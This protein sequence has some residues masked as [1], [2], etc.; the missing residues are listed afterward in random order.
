[1]PRLEENRGSEGLSPD[2]WA[3]VLEFLHMDEV[4]PISTLNKHFLNNVAPLIENIF[5]RSRSNLQPTTAIAR[6]RFAGVRNVRITCLVD[7][8]DEDG[9]LSRNKDVCEESA[10]GIPSFLASFPLLETAFLGG[11]SGKHPYYKPCINSFDSFDD[12]DVRAEEQRVQELGDPIALPVTFFMGPSHVQTADENLWFMKRMVQDLCQAYVAGGLSRNVQIDG[13]FYPRYDGRP[14]RARRCPFKASSMDESER[15]PPR[16]QVCP[17]ICR[18]FPPDQ[19]LSLDSWFNECVPVDDQLRIASQRDPS[20]LEEGLLTNILFTSIQ[21]FDLFSSDGAGG[22]KL[23]GIQY[24]DAT[25]QKIEWLIK[26]GANPR[27]PDIRQLLT[28]KPKLNP[29]ESLTSHGFDEDEGPEGQR[30]KVWSK[31]FRKF[32]EWKFDVTAA[33]FKILNLE[34]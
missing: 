20:I 32:E 17:L 29:W 13:L 2:L 23:E 15:H 28:S 7:G 18:S 19:V 14:S 16:C 27:H 3:K 5:V 1:M 30:R 8:V 12:E 33:D 4:L 25:C 6:K 21:M 11:E 10:L 31:A 9:F 24:S 22:V 26:R 34:E